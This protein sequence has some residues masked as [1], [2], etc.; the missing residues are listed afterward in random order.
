LKRRSFDRLHSATSKNASNNLIL[1]ID[2]DAVKNRSGGKR[3]MNALTTEKRRKGKGQFH[4]ISGEISGAMVSS[5]KKEKAALSAAFK[6]FRD[7]LS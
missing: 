4:F 5:T 1:Q 7:F 3:K 6:W 2:F